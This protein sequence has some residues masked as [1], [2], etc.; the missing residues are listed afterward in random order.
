MKKNY[1]IL[2][3]TADL[4][5][6]VFGNTKK[7]LFLN[8]VYAVASLQDPDLSEESVAKKIKIQSPDILSLLVDFLSEI[9]YLSQTEREVYLRAEFEEFSDTFLEAKLFGR[10]VKRF[11]EDIKGVTYHDLEI[12]Q[13]KNGTWEATILFDI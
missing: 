2:D 3:H 7:E 8:A 9:L 13:Q 10:K 6:R 12:K 4:K 11:R 5:I 1:E